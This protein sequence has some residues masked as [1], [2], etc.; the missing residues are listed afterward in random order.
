MENQ[1]YISKSRM[2][3][4]ISESHIDGQHITVNGMVYERISKVPT[5]RRLLRK[6]VNKDTNVRVK[7]YG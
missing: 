5:G 1:F 4:K 7:I 3:F 2:S 6:L